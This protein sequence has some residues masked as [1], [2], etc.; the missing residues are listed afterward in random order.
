MPNTEARAAGC[1]TERLSSRCG[2]LEP[3]DGRP[4][5]HAGA[6]N[7]AVGGG[8]FPVDRHDGAV[9][10]PPRSAFLARLDRPK[11]GGLRVDSKRCIK[12]ELYTYT[13]R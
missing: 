4:N 1:R 2:P 7:M 12:M 6:P 13:K 10:F 3:F 9:S 8:A 11:L 5:D